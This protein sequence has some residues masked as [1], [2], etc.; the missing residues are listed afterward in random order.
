MPEKKCF[1]CK[2]FVSLSEAEKQL[3]KQKLANHGLHGNFFG[4]CTYGNRTTNF[5]IN[6]Y[7]NYPVKHCPYY[8]Q[9]FYAERIGMACPQCKV[10][11]IV[12]RR[13]G[14]N[15]KTIIIIGCSRYPT[16]TYTA[17]SLRLCKPCRYCHVPLVLTAGE[18]LICHCPRCKRR[19]TIPLTLESRP[20]I[21]TVN[22]NCLHGSVEEDCSICQRSNNELRNLVD[23]EL[24]Q[25]VVRT[26]RLMKDEAE[27]TDSRSERTYVRNS[28]YDSFDEDNDII[29]IPPEEGDLQDE[30]YSEER[31]L[32]Y[33]ELSEYSEDW[34][35]SNEEGWFYDE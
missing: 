27:Y 21:F 1:N 2:F 14:K 16:C 11:D 28:S 6:R 25:V 26:Q 8:Q 24:A 31:E 23:I 32:L 30:D 15:G 22:G 13:P 5:I 17:S 4:A 18:Q 34:S 20:H 12:I 19:G 29:F 10:G 3:Y 9:G 33:Q 7:I 35:R